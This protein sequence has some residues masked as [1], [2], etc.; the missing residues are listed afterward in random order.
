MMR[1]LFCVVLMSVSSPAV[2]Q[3]SLG[4]TGAAF[5]LGATEDEGGNREPYGTAPVPASAADVEA[6]DDSTA[7]KEREKDKTHS[8]QTSRKTFVDPGRG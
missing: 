8:I 1:A 4:I 3:S 7:G 2:A 6:G 5:S